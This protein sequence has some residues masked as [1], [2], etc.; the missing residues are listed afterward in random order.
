MRALPDALNEL[1]VNVRPFDSIHRKHVSQSISQRIKLLLMCGDYTIHR[2]ARTSDTCLVDRESALRAAL[3]ICAKRYRVLSARGSDRYDVS[4][5]YGGPSAL[6]LPVKKSGVLPSR[7]KHTD[8]PIDAHD[9]LAFP[10]ER[11]RDPVDRLFV[12]WGQLESK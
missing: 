5:H 8:L 3:H 9:G 6:H 11:A 10:G 1:V 4:S 12:T 7:L 2:F